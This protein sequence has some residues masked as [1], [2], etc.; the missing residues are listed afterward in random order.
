MGMEERGCVEV[1]E[2][3]LGKGNE[4]RLG[5]EWVGGKYE[6][7]GMGGVMECGGLRGVGERVTRFGFGMGGAGRVNKTE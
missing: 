3:G 5:G 4:Q 6:G 1:G 2:G 7:L